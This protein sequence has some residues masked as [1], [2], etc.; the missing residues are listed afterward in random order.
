[1]FWREFQRG[2][3]VA[4]KNQV[5]FTAIGPYHAIEHVNRWMKV[6]GGII[7]IT[8]NESARTRLFL[9]APELARLVEASLHISQKT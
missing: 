8:F 5:P 4:N 1:M 7:V 2:N 3:I 6:A 9:T